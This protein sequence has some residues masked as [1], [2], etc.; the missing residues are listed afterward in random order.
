M[1]KVVMI[2]YRKEILYRKCHVYRVKNKQFVIPHP[3][4]KMRKNCENFIPNLTFLLF[5]VD[6]YC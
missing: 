5:G 2:Y 1:N 4:K 6:E 3:R